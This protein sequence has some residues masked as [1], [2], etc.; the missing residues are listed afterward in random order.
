MKKPK[1]KSGIKNKRLALEHQHVQ[2]P[3]GGKQRGQ[4]PVEIN[5]SLI[6]FYT[7]PYWKC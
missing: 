2:L 1:R 7:F 6:G 5:L 3:V 4:R